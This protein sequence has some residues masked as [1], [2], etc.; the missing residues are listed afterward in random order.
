MSTRASAPA[1]R[2]EAAPRRR[3]IANVPLAARMLIASVVVAILVGGVFIAL[4]L[5]ISTLRDATVREARAKAALTAAVTAENAVLDLETGLRGLILAEGDERFLGPAAKAKLELPQRLEALEQ[6]VASDPEQSRR[7]QG[8]KQAVNDYIN[9]YFVNVV[10]TSLGTAR[11]R[12]G[13][14]KRRRRA[15]GTPTRS[16]SALLRSRPPRTPRRRSARRPRPTGPIRRSR[17]GPSG[18]S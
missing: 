12:H 16:A 18:S 7:V 2:S 5:A 6:L 4:L 13:R 14:R 1:G 10:E 3:R 8:I 15:S 11:T 17:S 9:D